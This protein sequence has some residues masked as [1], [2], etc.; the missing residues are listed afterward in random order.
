M[1]DGTL[2]TTEVICQTTINAISDTIEECDESQ[3]AT[4]PAADVA[5]FDCACGGLDD[6]LVNVVGMS[7][8]TE[9]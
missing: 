5:V 9:A 1:K 7:V 6:G 8:M 2:K 3:R 4:Q